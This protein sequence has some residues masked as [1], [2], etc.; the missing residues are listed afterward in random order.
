M[1]IRLPSDWLR[2]LIE[3]EE[4]AGRRVRAIHLPRM[5]EQML[6]HE[7][8]E[9]GAVVTS[10]KGRRFMGIPVIPDADALKLEV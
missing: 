8:R 3:A 9:M 4:S 1:S 6:L 2:P 7:S 10:P 5:L